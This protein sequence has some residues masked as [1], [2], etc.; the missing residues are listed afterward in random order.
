VDT[1]DAGGKAELD[2]GK[3]IR[4][5][6]ELPPLEYDRVRNEEASRL[7]VRVPT[8]DSEVEKA[9]GGP[10]S[11][12]KAGSPIEFEELEPWDEPVAGDQLLDDIADLV[13]RHVVVPVGAKETTALWV[14][15]TY[16][17]DAMRVAPI[18]AVVSPEKRCGKTTLLTLLLALVYRQL[19]ASNISEAMVF[20]TIEAHKP[21]LIIDEVDTFME[22]NEAMRG[23]L[24]SGHTRATAY[25]IRGVGDQYEGRKFST[26]GPKVLAKIGSLPDTLA[27]R[28]IAIT[29][30]RKL[31]GHHVERM[32]L[33]LPD[34]TLD[35]RRQCASWFQEHGRSL[36]DS[37]PDLP[38]ELQNRDADNWRPL[39]AIAD[40]AGG[41][42]PKVAREV[43]RTAIAVSAEQEGSPAVLLLADIRTYFN[44]KKTEKCLSRELV[45]WL[46]MLEDRPWPAW[47]RG[48]PILPAQVARLLKR[49][50]IRPRTIRTGPDTGK[51]Y[52]RRDFED[53]FSRYLDN[54][55]VTP[56]QLAN[57][58]AFQGN[59]AVTLQDDVTAKKC[60][61]PIQDNDCDGVTAA[62]GGSGKWELAL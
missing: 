47:R 58:A 17:I 27:D 49:H 16:C 26:W 19:P 39:I 14:L 5:L 56:S 62:A 32:G 8:L 43:A 61:K 28:S 29:M 12:G 42:W 33:D 48:S 20:R 57:D 52:D 31:T 21:T 3:E 1:E 9:R 7:G 36:R 50:G 34:R 46:A 60:E 37:D 25:V 51:G 6:A 13:E 59:T 2:L 15:F 44:E 24:N 40:A 18:L 10:E 23:M 30:K 54:Q 22:D 53:A 55:A 11:D 4:M 38:V 35:I 45:P 41:R